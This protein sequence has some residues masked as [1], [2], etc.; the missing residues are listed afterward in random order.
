MQFATAWVDLEIARL[1]EV[2]QTEKG[3]C[4]EIT[5]VQ[6]QKKMIQMNLSMIQKQTHSLREQTGLLRG[7]MGLE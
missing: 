7:R 6:N 4:H 2:S 3:K 5:Y 1:S